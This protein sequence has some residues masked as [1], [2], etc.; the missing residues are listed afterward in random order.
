MTRDLTWFK[1]SRSNPT[2]NCVEVA[3]DGE[4][5]R[6]RDSKNPTGPQ[7]TFS[8]TAWKRFVEAVQEGTFVA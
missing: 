3:E 8:R 4:V 6:M 5:M 1:S 2:G 7:L